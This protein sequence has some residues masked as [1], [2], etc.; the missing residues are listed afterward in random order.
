MTIQQEYSPELAA[1]MV[2][3]KFLQFVHRAMFFF[4]FAALGLIFLSAG[5]MDACWMPLAFAL[6]SLALGAQ[7]LMLW[8]RT[9]TGTLIFRT[10][11]WFFPWIAFALLDAFV[12]SPVGWRA[13]YAFGMSLFPLIMFF[14]A[15]HQGRQGS[16]QN[17]FLGFFAVSLFF[18][19]FAGFLLTG[20][21]GEVSI[22][23]IEGVRR[24]LLGFS[25]NAGTVCTL[26]ILGFFFALILFLNKSISQH[27][28]MSMGCL[29]VG[30]LFV[31]FFLATGITWIAFGAGTL[32]TMLLTQEKMRK[33]AIAAVFVVAFSSFFALNSSFNDGPM[34][35]IPIPEASAIPIPERDAQPKYPLIATSLAMFAKNPLI[36]TGGES[37]PLEFEK[38]RPAQWNE[39][40][41]GPGSLYLEMLAENGL[42]GTILLLGVCAWFFVRLG[43]FTLKIAW[44]LP[45]DD[46]RVRHQLMPERVIV[47]GTLGAFVCIGILFLTSYPCNVPV[48]MIPIAAFA[49]VAMRLVCYEK[50]EVTLLGENKRRHAFF[51][52]AILAPAALIFFVF[53]IFHAQAHFEKGDEIVVHS[54]LA[55][56]N[57]ANQY[58]KQS[59]IQTR[60]Q[61]HFASAIVLNPRHADAWQ[62]LADS[63]CILSQS[64]P[65]KIAAYGQVI[66]FASGKALAQSQAVPAFYLARAA[67]ALMVNEFSAAKA[68]LE[69]AVEL[70]PNNVPLVLQA[71]DGLRV[72]PDATVRA[73]QLFQRLRV[74]APYSH[75][76][77]EVESLM[78]ISHPEIFPQKPT[79][80]APENVNVEKTKPNHFDL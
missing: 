76:I 25:G 78:Y 77:A 1:R 34:R 52:A 17:I 9:R 4:V 75:Y 36:G 12:F 11:F 40:P 61:V 47:A 59:K 19:L 6:F 48:V 23:G 57:G 15:Q 24:A 30:F 20:R 65:E 68:D 5:G 22:F 28:R 35:Q 80:F 49:G 56:E 21:A 42:L 43:L 64:S 69:E 74:L 27:I 62:R 72:L 32:V 31:L 33:R 58:D 7:F 29:L 55:V 38:T 26:A 41:R 53:P 14:I 8:W 45:R 71:A 46:W 16:A 39:T 73:A 18:F 79:R 3:E 50:Q 13:E 44:Y 37:F 51:V 63:Y 2:H 70:A 10:F 60:A 54:S 66:K 67:G